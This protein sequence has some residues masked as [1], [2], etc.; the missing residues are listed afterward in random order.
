MAFFSLDTPVSSTNL[1]PIAHLS[2]KESSL[3][4]KTTS[5]FCAQSRKLD[6]IMLSHIALLRSKTM[7]YLQEV[8]SLSVLIYTRE[9]HV[10]NFCQQQF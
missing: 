2:M 6:F 7:F 9:I 5:F 8:H 4:C 10:F 3:G 1:Q